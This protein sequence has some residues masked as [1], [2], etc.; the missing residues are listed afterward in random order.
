LILRR[1]NISIK[2]IRRVFNAPGSDAVLEVLDKKIVDIDEEVALLHELKDI[3]IDFIRQIRDAD[4]SKDSDV[5]L[6]YEKAKDIETQLSNVDYGGNPSGVNR[7]VEVTEKLGQ[8]EDIVKKTRFYIILN[9]SDSVGAYKLYQLAFGAEGIAKTSEE[10]SEGED[11]HIGMDVNGFYILLM[12]EPE[13]ANRS[14]GCAVEFASEN[15]LRAA[16]DV[17]IREGSDY[18]VDTNAGWTTLCAWVTDKYNVTWFF[19]V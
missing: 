16:Y 7:F 8:K 3:I 6:L 13:P 17:L 9:V 11:V 12:T 14:G 5:K 10:E 15:G 19:C 2:D 1:L 4:F 18:S